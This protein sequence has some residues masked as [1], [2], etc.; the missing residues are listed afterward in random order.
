MHAVLKHQKC[1]HIVN[2]ISEKDPTRKSWMQWLCQPPL[3]YSYLYSLVS[4]LNHNYIPI[5][6][7]TSL[8]TGFYFSILTTVFCIRDFDASFEI[9]SISRFVSD[10]KCSSLVYLKSK[11]SIS[12]QHSHFPYHA[13]FI[14]VYSLTLWS[15]FMHAIY[16]LSLD[17]VLAMV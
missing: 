6:S 11:H 9:S 16:L 2:E 5:N 15:V 7:L 3:T 8:N 4:S 13:L 10:L 14:V 1:T 12:G 17:L